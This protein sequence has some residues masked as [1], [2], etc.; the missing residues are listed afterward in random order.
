MFV[1]NEVDNTR[2]NCVYRGGCYI[3]IIAKVIWGAT[4]VN[5]FK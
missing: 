1:L 4:E 5:Y 2:K 3:E